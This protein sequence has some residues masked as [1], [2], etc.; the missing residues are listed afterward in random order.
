MAKKKRKP[1]TAE[2][3][4]PTTSVQL[5]P[6]AQA[7]KEDLTCE[8]ELRKL[9]SASLI[10]FARQDYLAQK[11]LIIEASGGNNSVLDDIEYVKHSE[12]L[13]VEADMKKAIFLDHAVER[14]GWDDVKARLDIP[15][16]EDIPLDAAC[17]PAPVSVERAAM[18]MKNAIQIHPRLPATDKKIVDDFLAGLDIIRKAGGVPAKASARDKSPRQ[19]RSQRGSAKGA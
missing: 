14:F 1:A 18:A 3:K 4:A 5:S 9:L 13:R 7:I 11:K 15:Q 10:L 17:L 12:Q 16:A 8:W 19:S 6:P 2:D